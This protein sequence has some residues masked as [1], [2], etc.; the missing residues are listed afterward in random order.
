MRTAAST[1]GERTININYKVKKRERGG[2]REGKGGRRERGQKGVVPNRV[3][4]AIW[5]AICIMSCISS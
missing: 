4:S 1:V 5:F 2:G 3:C